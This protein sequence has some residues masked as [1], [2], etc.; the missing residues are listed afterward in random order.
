MLTIQDFQKTVSRSNAGFLDIENNVLVKHDT[1]KH[2][3]FTHA[4]SDPVKNRQVR[5][6]LFNALTNDSCGMK[7]SEDYIARLRAELIPNANVAASK[8]MRTT[9]K[10]LLDRHVRLRDT[11][12]A[13]GPQKALA[14]AAKELGSCTDQ[15]VGRIGGLIGGAGSTATKPLTAMEV[16]ELLPA[17]ILKPALVAKIKG[18]AAAAEKK[19]GVAYRLVGR[20]LGSRVGQDKLAKARDALV[21]LGDDLRRVFNGFAHHGRTAPAGL[22]SAIAYCMSR[23]AELED[24]LQSAKKLASSERS[25]AKLVADRAMEMHGSKDFVRMVSA[26]AKDLS[27]KIAALE[28]GGNRTVSAQDVKAL[29]SGVEALRAQVLAAGDGGVD[30]GTKDLAR[31]KNGV[32]VV[33]RS[34]ADALIKELNVL[35]QRIEKLSSSKFETLADAFLEDYFVR[36]LSGEKNAAYVD[37]ARGLCAKMSSAVRQGEDWH[38][39]VDRVISGYVQEHW[40][41]TGRPAALGVQAL[42]ALRGQLGQL[43]KLCADGLAVKAE[44][45]LTVLKG[46]TDMGT[47]IAANAFGFELEDVDLRLD[48]R[49]LVTSKKLGAGLVNE[50]LELTY[51]VPGPNGKSETLTRVF[52][53]EITARVGLAELQAGLDNA[54]IN[55]VARLNRATHRA[56]K[57][58][59]VP[60]L[61][62]PITVGVHDGRLGF[63]MMKADSVPRD[64][65]RQRIA[66]DSGGNRAK[67]TLLR[68]LTG[69]AWL[70]WLTGQMD[71][72]HNNYLVSFNGKGEAVVK[73]IDNDASFAATRRGVQKFE[74]TNDRL[75]QMA[76][77]AGKGMTAEGIKVKYAKHIKEVK[78]TLK[79]D[80]PVLEIDLEGADTNLRTL[81]ALTYGIKTTM[82]PKLITKAMYDKLS[83]LK[84]KGNE[85]LIKMATEIMGKTGFTKEQRVMTTKRLKEMVDYVTQTPPPVWVVPDNDWTAK[86][87]ELDKFE[88]IG[89]QTF[90]RGYFERDFS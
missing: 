68:E 59:G 70:D 50:V 85:E 49:N 7:F 54:A 37:Q 11:L 56:A 90:A 16:M 2:F 58:L 17:A 82:R 22:E 45:L 79:G 42:E 48:D 62:D 9:V 75:N 18:E 33:E 38:A 73:G 20:D 61:V 26:K 44:H 28:T 55:S 31:G 8:L 63:F 47:V 27:G 53:P 35:S 51:S 81:V 87:D 40:K 64:L 46:R 78:G 76:A 30:I 32:F 88:R 36:S 24:V 41:D 3:Q 80:P 83:A 69:L 65:V 39:A 67:G 86:V 34:L 19:L 29:T 21:N 52:K 10:S 25:V 13:Y 4:T 71:R 57:F 89:R 15:D 72:H 77:E 6:A 5:E 23:G 74:L 43:H 60:Q 12:D 66:S 14:V 1:H 84:G